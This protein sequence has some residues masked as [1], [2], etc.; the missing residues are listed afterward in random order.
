MFTSEP[1]VIDR[2]QLFQAYRQSP[3]ALT[4]IQNLLYLE[5]AK[6]TNQIF[7]QQERS[8]FLQ[9]INVFYQF[10]F[11]PTVLFLLT[12]GTPTIIPATCVSYWF[13]LKWYDTNILSY[14]EKL[15]RQGKKS[16]GFTHIAGWGLI[17]LLSSSHNWLATGLWPHWRL[18]STSQGW[19]CPGCW[20][21]DPWRSS[22]HP[23][24]QRCSR[25]LQ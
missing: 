7:Q 13:S 24:W 21:T 11:V 14:W 18:L 23:D 20:S 22:A 1:S 12:N 2:N 16:L 8:F 5:W 9:L 10:A 25:T 17:L 19:S 3:H 4:W 15:L 6:A